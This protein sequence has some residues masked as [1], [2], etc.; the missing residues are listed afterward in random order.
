MVNVTSVHNSCLPRRL[1]VVSEELDQGSSDP[2]TKRYVRGTFG[3]GAAGKE[4][5]GREYSA[6]KAAS[7]TTASGRTDGAKPEGSGDSADA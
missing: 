5:R 6:S 3:T 2:L 7:E 1:G 4:M